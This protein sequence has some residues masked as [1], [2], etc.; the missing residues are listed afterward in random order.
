MIGIDNYEEYFLDYIEGRLDEAGRR[1]VDRFVVAHPEL[2]S[3]L[4]EFLDSPVLEPT[5]VKMPGA[6]ADSLRH[7]SDYDEPDVPYFDRLAVLNLEKIATPAEKLEYSRMKYES[8]E[9]SRIARIYGKTVLTPDEFEYPEKRRLMVFPLWRRIAPYAA[10]AAVASLMVWLWPSAGDGGAD[11]DVNTTPMVVQTVAP[12][13]TPATCNIDSSSQ[14][15]H[16]A[17]NPQVVDVEVITNTSRSDA[18]VTVAAKDE[19]TTESVAI[20]SVAVNNTTAPEIDGVAVN[21]TTAPEIDGVAV[22]NTTAPEIY[23]VAVN[24]TTAPEIVA[25]IVTDSLAGNIAVA[26]S[27][28]LLQDDI[29]VKLLPFSEVAG[30]YDDD[31]DNIDNRDNDKPRSRRKFWFVCG[32]ILKRV[33]RRIVPDVYFD[34]DHNAEGKVSRVAMYMPNKVYTLERR[35]L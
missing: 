34:V 6:L 9:C 27:V 28:L 29:N 25:E 19:G 31:D 18:S 33:T 14:S 12:V 3:E 35:R 21:N 8:Q 16:Y 32:K 24:N 10:A 22:N 23:G 7:T 4:E 20:E 2:R 11:V 5:S 15:Q 30:S 26:D 1:E 17:S 13:E